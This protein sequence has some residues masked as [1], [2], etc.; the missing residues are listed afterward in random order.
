MRDVA[1]IALGSNLGDRAGHLA[2]ARSALATLPS[3]RVVAESSIEETEP[4]GGLEQPRYLN[5]M[6]ALETSLSPHELL[7][8]LRDIETAEGRT[9]HERWASR[10]L[11]LDIVCFDRQAVSTEELRVPHPGLDDR[12]FWQRELKELREAIASERA[13]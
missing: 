11:D 9:R 3:S 2:R 8:R 1:F 7:G 12:V 6:I 10:T 4:L 13:R 5:Q